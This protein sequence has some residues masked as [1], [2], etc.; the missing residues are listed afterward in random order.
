MS[1]RETHPLRWGCLRL[2]AFASAGGLLG[3]VLALWEMHAQGKPP[4]QGASYGEYIAIM[5]TGSAAML[6]VLAGLAIVPMAMHGF[7]R[8]VPQGEPD[9]LNQEE[10]SESRPS[11]QENPG[12]PVGPGSPWRPTLFFFVMFT[13]IGL[14][15]GLMTSAFN[16][17]PEDNALATALAMGL[18][19]IVPGACWAFVERLVERRGGDWQSRVKAA[20]HRLV[21]WTLLGFLI[22]G[23]LGAA[24][25]VV[26][27][28]MFSANI[29]TWGETT[30]A[31][32]SVGF[33]GGGIWGISF[34]LLACLVR[35]IMEKDRA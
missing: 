32:L 20:R 31:V 2:L 11:E 34:G 22:V 19:G 29:P 28:L 6:S 30:R 35:T 7:F 25:M 24:L 33:L 1:Q 12:Q 3:V 26:L 17:S 10:A 8:G 9:A 16:P 18:V 23:C 13:V 14:L 4:G 15:L 27:V 5:A 21:S